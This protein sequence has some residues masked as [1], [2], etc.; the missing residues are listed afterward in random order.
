MTKRKNITNVKK[1]TSFLVTP[2]NLVHGTSSQVTLII[3]GSIGAKYRIVAKDTNGNY[4]GV[5]LNYSKEPGWSRANVTGEPS[6]L[7]TFR[8]YCMVTIPFSNFNETYSFYVE[9]HEG[10]MLSQ[11]VADQN[12]PIQKKFFGKKLIGHDFNCTVAGVNVSQDDTNIFVIP[13]RSYKAINGQ[14]L[15]EG[16]IVVSHASNNVLSSVKNFT[17]HDNLVTINIVS[18]SGESIPIRSDDAIFAEDDVSFSAS[19]LNTDNATKDVHINYSI[20]VSK[21]PFLDGTR[22]I[23]TVDLDQIITAS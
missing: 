3:G 12:N 15:L 20:L 6:T 5:D 16:T 1:I 9:P 18:D 23:F 4:Y 21:A 7:N 8:K 22:L 11:G 19:L 13:G 2:K 17:M 10:T 14:G